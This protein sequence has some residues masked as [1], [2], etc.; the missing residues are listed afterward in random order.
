MTLVFAMVSIVTARD[1]S[2]GVLNQMVDGEK[3]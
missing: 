1:S 2:R 3:G